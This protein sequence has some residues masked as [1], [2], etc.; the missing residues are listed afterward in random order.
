ML[1]VIIVNYKK[2]LHL[3]IVFGIVSV[4]LL[5]ILLA[6]LREKALIENAAMYEEYQ[7]GQIFNLEL[8]RQAKIN[9]NLHR[10][11]LEDPLFKKA[12]Q[13]HDER[14]LH[15]R[16]STIFRDLRL[17]EEYLSFINLYLVAP[18]GITVLGCSKITD[19]CTTKII[20]PEVL[21]QTDRVQNGFAV[22]DGELNFISRQP[23]AVN[24]TV[25]AMLETGV[26]A[27]TFIARFSD[28]LGGYGGILLTKPASA[29]L[30]RIDREFAGHLLILSNYQGFLKLPETFD[31]NLDDHHLVQGSHTFHL[32]TERILT[33]IDGKPMGH[34]LL[35]VDHSQSRNALWGYIITAAI[36]T[37]LL[38]GGVYYLSNILLGRITRKIAKNQNDIEE[39]NAELVQK[40]DLK[41]KESDTSRAFLN[42]YKQAV[43]ES[44]IVSK[45]DVKGIITYVNDEFVRI[46]GYTK[47]ELIGRAHNV[48]RHPEMPE[49]VFEELWRTIKA[50]KIWKGVIKNR[51]KDGSDYLVDSTIVP[52]MDSQGEIVE[53]I[54][55]R[56]DITDLVAREKELKEIKTDEL[57]GLGNRNALKE[58][59]ETPGSHLLAILNVD[60]YREIKDFYG[61][62]VTDAIIKALSDTLVH[63]PFLKPYGIYKIT[64][65]QFALLYHTPLDDQNTV[66]KIA[67]C[68]R[69]LNKS[70]IVFDSYEI[71]VDITAGIAYEPDGDQ[72]FRNADLALKEARR[73]NIDLFRYQEGINILEEYERNIFWT[74]QLKKAISSDRLVAYFQPIV[75]NET[76]RFDKYEALIRLINEDGSITSPYLFLDMAKR[77]RLYPSIT[78]TIIRQS[79]EVFQNNDREFS[80]NLTADDIHNKKTV[81]FLERSLTESGMADRCV[82]EITESEEIKDY[83]RVVD[84]IKHFKSLGCKVAIDDFGSGY[85]N[86]NYIADLGADYIKI[87]GSLIKHIDTD[88][89]SE[90][91]V[92]TIMTFAK[93]MGM[94]TVAEFVSSEAIYKKV[95]EL[96]VDY[97]QGFY[98]A[99]PAREIQREA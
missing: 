34:F 21:G 75:N 32:H 71:Y 13:A 26:S 84:F 82:L 37:L 2:N 11:L 92:R 17:S 20:A 61:V 19:S 96:G 41:T 23:M 43:D 52:V 12:L 1:W 10:T 89:T 95:K 70:P 58:E 45:T 60:N 55:I 27:Q 93:S 98:F 66:S 53:F 39:L 35:L 49:S 74:S 78:Q 28:I 16:I 5:Y 31:L 30:T 76:G 99:E 69:T 67:G 14:S 36:V 80:I 47:E 90:M 88:P 62:E 63:H 73:R 3:I 81:E 50:R 42:S 8:V 18:K 59:L 64:A 4:A 54:G 33:G 91:I 22:A 24:D 85:S 87:D 9:T 83:K 72:I 97:S 51:R 44:N 57:T 25:V 56:H 29:P 46:S 79:I 6:F 40:A 7:I 77:S 15:V 86:F 48:I 38:L 94:K 68:L 65:E